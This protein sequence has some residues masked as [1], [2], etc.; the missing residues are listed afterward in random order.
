LKR[1]VIKEKYIILKGYPF[2]KYGKAIGKILLIALAG[3][4]GQPTPTDIRDKKVIW[5]VKA[6][7]IEEYTTTF[8]ENAVKATLHTDTQYKMHPERY[9]LLAVIRK[10][11]SGGDTLLLDGKKI[12]K[13]LKRTK[14]GRA[15]LKILQKNKFPFRVPTVYT[16]KRKEDNPEVIW[17]PVISKR[18]LL[19]FR[20]DTIMRGFACTME[21][22]EMQRAVEYFEQYCNRHKEVRKVLLQRGEIIIMKNDEMLHGRTEFKDKKRHLL[23]IRMQ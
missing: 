9:V 22:E 19:R 23:R 14:R 3:I 13:Q 8:S 4:F 5:D 7:D 10:A 17:C 12:L 6:R 11:I 21:N 16:K 15:C 2:T 18:P 20:K 1:S